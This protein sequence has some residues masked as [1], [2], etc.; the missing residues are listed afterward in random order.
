MIDKE[1][2]T[3][4]NSTLSQKQKQ[5][6]QLNC[7]VES[8][9]SEINK[10]N[11]VTLELQEDLEQQRSKNDVRFFLLNIKKFEKQLAI[12]ML[13]SLY[14]NFLHHQR[15]IYYYYFLNHRL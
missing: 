10:Q 6:D 1:Q 5:L 9:I 14:I 2:L 7:Q 8:L 4:L 12:H 11:K 13:P 3:A 15:F